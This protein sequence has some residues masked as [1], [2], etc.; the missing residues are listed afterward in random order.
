VSLVL[1]GS[2]HNN[3]CLLQLNEV[4]MPNPFDRPRA[5]FMLE[6]RGTGLCT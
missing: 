3:V 6:V 4:L 1:D 2:A 5:V